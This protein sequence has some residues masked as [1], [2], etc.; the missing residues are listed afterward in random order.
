V[1]YPEDTFILPFDL[2]SVKEMEN[3]LQLRSERHNYI[4]MLP[5]L[6]SAIAAKKQEEKSE[7]PFRKL[8]VGELMSKVGFDYEEASALTLELVTWWKLA[9]RWHRPLVKEPEAEAKALKMIVEE[10]TRRKKAQGLSAESDWLAQGRLTSTEGMLAIF[11]KPDGTYLGVAEQEEPYLRHY[12][13]AAS[14]RGEVKQ[15]G[16]WQLPSPGLKRWRKVWASPAYSKWPTNPSIQDYLS[17]PEKEEAL[18]QILRQAQTVRDK[19]VVLMAVTYKTKEREFEIWLSP[20]QGKIDYEHLL[21]RGLGNLYLPFIHGG[22]KRTKGGKVSVAVE[23]NWIHQYNW[24]KD[25]WRREGRKVLWE[26]ASAIARARLW[27]QKCEQAEEQ[28]HELFEKMLDLEKSVEQAW[29]K[30]NEAREYARFIEDYQDPDLW[31]GHKKTLKQVRMPGSDA[32]RKLTEIAVE[33]G[34]EVIGLSAEEAR[35]AAFKV[36]GKAKTFKDEDG[37]IEKVAVPKAEELAA[38]AHLR[39]AAKIEPAVEEEEAGDGDEAPYTMDF[40]AD[41]SEDDDA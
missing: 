20:E 15:V 35:E 19:K 11:Q 17:G 38:L 34:I 27:K 24:D 2:V 29:E 30:E 16:E 31:E 28:R 25:E 18:A 7:E 21:T 33:R 5:L 1:L 26:D 3:Y 40:S 10:A 32:L 37:F 39:Y 36:A 4:D 9:N 13:L 8:I 23:T 6:K 12:T 41:E 14:G 22:W